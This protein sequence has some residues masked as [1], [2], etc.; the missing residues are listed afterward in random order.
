MPVPDFMQLEEAA[1]LPI[2]FLTASYAL[3]HLAGITKGDRVLIHAATGGVG[4][5][6]I[7]IAQQAG[8][9]IFATAGSPEKRDFL[10]GIGIKHVMDSRSLAFYDEI[11]EV[12][13]GEGVDIVLNSLAGQA[14]SRSLALLRDYGRFL[15]I[16]KRD[17]YQNTRIGLRAFRKNVSYHAIDLSRTI[18]DRVPLVR[19][20]LDD[21]SK[22]FLEET[23]RPLPQLVFSQSQIPAAFRAMRQARH[24]GK[25]VISF[26]DE[27]VPIE[28]TT[29]SGGCPVRNDGSYLVT[30]GTSGFGLVSAQWLA[31]Q[32]AGALVLLSRSGAVSEEAKKAIAAM[33]TQG[34]R[35]LT[36]MADVCSMADVS[37]VLE[38]IRSAGLPELR[39]VFHAAMVLDDAG[40]A[41][42]NPE[43]FHR[44]FAP[45]AYGSWV[46]HQ[47]TEDYN[48]DFFTMYSSI[49]SVIGSPGQANYA[50][51]N[52]FLEALAHRRKASGKPGLA[53][54]WGHIG[55][56]G[57]ASRSE[58]ISE[59]LN[60]SGFLAMNPRTAIEIKGKLIQHGHTQTVVADLDWKLM[61]GSFLRAEKSPRYGRILA[62]I[63]QGDSEGIPP[64][65][66][67]ECSPVQRTNSPR[68]CRN[69]SIIWLP[70]SCEPLLRKWK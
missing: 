55:E 62:E 4:L 58:K 52:V 43:R 27:K 22:R 64:G 66:G 47:L 18:A 6:A 41:D 24:I 65:F 33:E 1:T 29:E 38:E 10:R 17:I 28:F 48:L 7:Q 36:P 42:Q 9:E 61:D 40:L 26:T 15:E 63:D 51:A 2:V 32:G 56:T 67:N 60:R 59:H 5:A 14:I 30:G 39:G 31:D 12:T 23:L 37:C 45:K 35:V 57:V 70:G 25:L 68:S 49:N 54:N 50:A 11:R 20:L 69:T 13:N 34:V 44:T 8:A 53:V 21:L 19:S 3:E 16:G 46:L